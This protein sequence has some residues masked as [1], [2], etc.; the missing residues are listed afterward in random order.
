VKKSIAL[1]CALAIL[2]AI[3]SHPAA[4][5]PAPPSLRL[6]GKTRPTGYEV[7]LTI[8]PA[9]EDFSGKIDIDLVLSEPQ[10]LLWV[11]GSRL[12]VGKA[13]LTDAK[14]T[15]DARPVP[16]GDEFV[17]FELT[18]EAAV[19]AARLTVEYTGRLDRNET[20]GLFEQKD[21]VDW[22]AFSQF[23]S[24]DARRAFPCF[25]EPS[26]KVPWRLTLVIPAGDTAVS[27]TPELSETPAT[28]GMK[29]VR[30]G[31]TRPL[32]S[33]LVALGVGPFDIVGAG[34]AGAGHTPLRIIALKG[35]GAQA[36]YAAKA[37]GPLL[38]LLEEY[39]GIPYPYEKLDSL[40]IPQTVGF[41]A[42]EN[43]GLITYAE[44]IL[45]AESGEDTVSFERRYA[46]VA[47]HEMGHQWTGDL[48]TMAWWN[49]IWL[50]EGFAN[51]IENKIVARWK[52]EWGEDAARVAERSAAMEG[53][54]LVAARRVRQPIE[55]P[56]DILNAFDNITY[57]KGAALLSM[58]EAWMGEKKFQSGMNR[59]L[60]AHADGNA[61]SE[62]FLSAL[63][64]EGPPGVGPAFA[65]FLD[66]PGAPL[67]TV[68]LECSAAGRASLKVS[69]KRFLPLGSSGRAG[70]LWK[71]PLCL[72]ESAGGREERFCTL[73][74]SAEQEIPLPEA[75]CPEWV[76]A[77]DGESGYYR[78]LYGGNL[79]D[80]LLG[81][82]A[83][84]L[85]VPE[86][87][88]L[89]GDVAALA[90]GGALGRDR[91][92]ALVPEF[93][94]GSSRRLVE[95][96]ARIARDVNEH[97]VPDRLEPNYERFVRSSFG[98]KAREMGFS[99]RPGESEDE[100]LLRPTV[101]SLA[102]R[103]GED[104]VLDAEA[105]RL[106]RR[107]L[108]D[109]S[110]FGADMADTVLEAAARGGDR[111]LFRLFVAEAKKIHSRQDRRRIF[112]ALGCFREPRLRGEALAL[113]LDRELDPREGILVL[114]GMLD[115]KGGRE[116]AYEYFKKNFDAITARLPV[117]SS[118]RLFRVGRDFCDE[119]HRRDIEAFFGP[120]TDKFPGS[121]RILAQAV[122]TV[123]LCEAMRA[124]EEP[125]VAK[126]LEK[127]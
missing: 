126:F 96:A 25:D 71:I 105:G 44:S 69:Q 43:A 87:V 20:R 60:R 52:P 76:L 21:G 91:A 98:Q 117:E 9:R 112:L 6:D 26:Y 113:L 1:P 29:R 124:A 22:Y 104:P 103:E 14:G 45:L 97:L 13:S 79:L 101:V 119:P 32:P 7:E 30:F 92:L 74:D 31:K 39:F 10:K 12:T 72:R 67:V 41:G 16:G 118:A 86:R 125:A 81:D 123:G 34:T 64:A 107:W 24:V 70:E 108:K 84:E 58:F 50:N 94:R 100:T 89:V 88:G 53:D 111:E 36:A 47:A 114:Y 115:E 46:S 38:G 80:R 90:E 15:V 63:E 49:D 120:K 61:T 59:Y 78:T 65:T 121:P 5:S 37:T 11:N 109:R 93:S 66:Q 19:G 23:E 106:A 83:R 77:N 2:S 57:G 33:Y 62:D 68:D 95:A 17:G 42:M 56:G 35:K 48:V 18:R 40:A 85:T 110:A 122:E 102:V 82:S 73:V 8:D 27:N 116:A 51:W 4:G 127:Y 75:G 54:T 99:P 55:T 28:G 3:L